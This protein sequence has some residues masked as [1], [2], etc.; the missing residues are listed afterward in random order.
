VSALSR[1]NK[2]RLGTEVGAIIYACRAGEAK[3]SDHLWTDGA[4]QFGTKGRKVARD[5]VHRGRASRR[6][7]RNNQ[8]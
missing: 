5:N 7:G 2:S 8:N 4:R 3:V 6:E 1:A